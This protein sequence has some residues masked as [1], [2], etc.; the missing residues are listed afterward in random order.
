MV[1]GEG[2]EVDPGFAGGEG[3]GVSYYWVGEGAWWL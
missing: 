3:E 1:V 2:F